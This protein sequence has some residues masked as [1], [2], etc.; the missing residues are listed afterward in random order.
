MSGWKFFAILALFGGVGMLG[1]QI[2]D[3][4]NATSTNTL[5]A[6]I[7]MICG[8]GGFVALAQNDAFSGAGTAA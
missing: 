2:G 6:S 4:W 1:W 7:A 3:N 8:G 5:I